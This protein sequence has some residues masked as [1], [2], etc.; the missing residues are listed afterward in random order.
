MTIHQLNPLTK[1]SIEIVLTRDELIAFKQAVAGL[2][3]YGGTAEMTVDNLMTALA[4]DVAMT[5]T[6]PG[7]WGAANM[8]QVFASHGWDEYCG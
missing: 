2:S 6:R 7:G 5:V 4:E 1:L 3:E 8:Q